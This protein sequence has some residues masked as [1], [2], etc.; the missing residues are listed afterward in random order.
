MTPPDSAVDLMT[1]VPPS[2]TTTLTPNGANLGASAIINDNTMRNVDESPMLNTD[3]TTCGH[4][5]SRHMRQPT[6]GESV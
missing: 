3:A 4:D 1:R 5:S 2:A 6:N